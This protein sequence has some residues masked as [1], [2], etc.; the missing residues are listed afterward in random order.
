[1]LFHVIH[2]PPVLATILAEVF[3]DKTKSGLPHKL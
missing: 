3:S 1:V 2:R